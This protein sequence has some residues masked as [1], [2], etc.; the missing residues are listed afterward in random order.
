M[1]Q[2]ARILGRRNYSLKLEGSPGLRPGLTGPGANAEAL[3]SGAGSRI[4]GLPSLLI[5]KARQELDVFRRLLKLA[6]GFG[7]F[8]LPMSALALLSSLFEGISLALIIPLVQI[9][10]APDLPAHQGH[11]LLQ[12]LYEGVAAI[13]V[14]MRLF[15]VL[16]SMLA[17]IIVKSAISYANMA[18]LVIVYGRLS[19]TLRRGVFA[20]ILQ[21]PLAEVEREPSGRLLNILNNETW[22]ATDALNYLFSI[23]TAVA[24]MVVFVAL[25]FLLSWRLSLIALAFMA[26]IPPL[27]QLITWRVKQLSAL[28]LDANEALAQRTWT[29]L[30]GVRIIHAFGRETFEATRFSQTSDKVRR[31]FLKLALISMTTGPIT[32]VLVTGVVALLA[33]LVN[34]SHVSVGT[35]VAFLAILYRLQPRLVGFVSSLASL[36]GVHAPVMAVSK[37]LAAPY[38]PVN[39]G[40]KRQFLGLR[41]GLRF[42]SVTFTHESA[43]RPA[44]SE[45]SFDATQ[46]NMV[47]LV[48]PSGAGKSTL[49]DLLL[50]FYEPQHGE[51]LADG[52][53]IGE[54]DIASWRA[55]LAVVSQDPYIFDDT[56]RANILYGRLQASEAEMVHAAV[57]ACADDFIRELPMGYDTQVGERGTQI[58]GG[59][60][61]RLALARALVRDPDILILDEATNALDT[62]TER[63]FQEALEHFAR[64]RLVFVVAHRLATIENADRVV[65][66]DAGR[67]VETGPPRALL[68]AGGP[69]SQLFLSQHLT[70]SDDRSGNWTRTT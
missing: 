57:L 39:P 22:R 5:Q 61:Q 38:Q 6:E 17:A 24:T 30:N 8:L 9:L 69:F 43:S 31:L 45:V 29:T 56:V 68:A 32:E 1:R 19:H 52:I 7:S 62:V 25:L 26:I 13:P 53:P 28:S 34:A 11:F 47:A 2:G 63:A 55:R 35:L 65:V 12:L 50:R 60:R 46:G 23:I 66:L 27:V 40:A 16:A 64:H 44:V 54:L 36:R 15:V 3:G 21:R 18:L 10:D 70:A 41:V 4:T 42:D 58:S 37:A 49:L 14:E 33:F 48:G 59:Q 20:R 67:V 51:I